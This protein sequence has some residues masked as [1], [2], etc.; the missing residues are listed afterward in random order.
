MTRDAS[1]GRNEERLLKEPRSQVKLPALNVFRYT[2]RLILL[3]TS[4][5]D[6]K[7]RLEEQFIEARSSINTQICQ[8]SIRFKHNIAEDEE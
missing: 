8:H 5:Q 6:E 3:L 1:Y 7:L 2:S 4:M